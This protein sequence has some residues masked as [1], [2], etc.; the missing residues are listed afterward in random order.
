MSGAAEMMRERGLDDIIVVEGRSLVG[1]LSL[2]ETGAA[3]TGLQA[4]L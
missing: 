4:A 2:A 3:E 1:A